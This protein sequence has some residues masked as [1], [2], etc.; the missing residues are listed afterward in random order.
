MPTLSTSSNP[1]QADIFLSEAQGSRSRDNAVVTMAAGVALPSGSLLTKAG[2]KYVKYA[3]GV[4]ACDAV[5]ITKLASQAAVGDQK[6]A[7]F[8]RDCEI[9]ALGLV[10]SDANAI[11]KLALAGVIVRTSTGLA[12]TY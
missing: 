5:L 1:G 7:V 3:G 11:A 12:G 10:G 2:L 6:A 8:V 4:T 9:N